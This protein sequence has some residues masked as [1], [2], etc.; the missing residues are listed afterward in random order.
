MNTVHS[1]F[2]T[3]TRFYFV[4]LLT[5]LLCACQEQH[6]E[7]V[8][9]AP[10]SSETTEAAVITPVEHPIWSF[11][12][13]IYEI[14]VRHFSRSQNFAG[15]AGSLER[16]DKMGV[17]IIW[18]MPI[19]P[20]GKIRRQGRKGNPYAISD[21]RT[22]DPALGNIAEF[23]SLVKKIHEHGMYVI[24]DL[25][26]YHTA[27]DHILMTESPDFYARDESGNL[28]TPVEGWPDVVQLDWDKPGVRRYIFESMRFWVEQ[29]GVDGFRCDLAGLVPIDFWQE[30][31]QKLSAS[32]PILM[33]ADWEAPELHNGA[34]DITYARNLYNLMNGIAAGHA[35]AFSLEAYFAE[36]ARSYPS[37]AFR[38]YYTETHEE[39]SWEAPAPKRLGKALEPLTVLTLTANGIP[40][41]FNGQETRLRRQLSLYESDR[42]PWRNDDIADLYARLLKLRRTNPA[43]W[44]GNRGGAMVRIPSTNNNAI[45]AFM[46]TRD[47]Q[48]VVVVMNLSSDQQSIYLGGEEHF[49]YYLDNA[50]DSPVVLDDHTILELPPWGYQVLVLSKKPESEAIA[51]NGS[52][53]M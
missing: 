22:V 49:G 3:Q 1:F 9:A 53:E 51:T 31:R 32:K 44:N 47:R 33:L 28:I 23:R 41:I 4:L 12:K 11:N 13:G 24:L 20:I 50:N 40:L 10:D 2:L 5:L 29:I 18:L 42:I 27:R 16:L 30:A 36:E 38:L 35:D 52:P 26:S 17:G 21:H 34:F 6:Q 14:N 37:N 25:I 43:L 7:P 39:N 19:Y 15:V 48:R 46:R 8:V 45:F